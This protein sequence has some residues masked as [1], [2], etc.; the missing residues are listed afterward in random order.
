MFTN[1]IL[2]FMVSGFEPERSTSIPDATKDPLNACALRALKIHGSKIAVVGRLQFTM[3]DV[4]EENFPP[5]KIENSDFILVV[6]SKISLLTFMKIFV[7][8]F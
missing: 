6:N 3:V 4:S 2:V 8:L 1:G 7:V 5:F